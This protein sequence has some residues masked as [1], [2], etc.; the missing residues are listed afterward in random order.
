MSH[1]E[2]IATVRKVIELKKLFAEIIYP[3]K[4]ILVLGRKVSI[5]V[6]PEN[7][8]GRWEEFNIPKN[9]DELNKL[10]V[11]EMIVQHLSIALGWGI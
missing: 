2:D 3:D 10:D 9:I 1:E 11:D 7:M 8:G 5:W 4:K 6:G